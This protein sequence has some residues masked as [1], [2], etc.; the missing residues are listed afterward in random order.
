MPTSRAL[1]WTPRVLGLCVTVFIGL[2]ALDAF[3]GQGF[4]A[5]LPGFLLHLVPSFILLATVLVAWR[6]AGVGAAVFLG[7]AAF[8]AIVAS[9]H[10]AWV[11]GISGPLALVG[12][13]YL[14]NW[15]RSR[16]GPAR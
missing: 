6:H 4:W 15:R 16:P 8:Y 13:L 3:E 14:L 2:F 11:V 12:V 5:S 7:L 9:R 1:V 10:P